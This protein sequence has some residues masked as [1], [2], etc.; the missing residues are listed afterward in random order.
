MIARRGTCALRGAGDLRLRGLGGRIDSAGRRITMLLG[1]DNG[2]RFAEAWSLRLRRLTGA[3]GYREP[4]F[5]F[6]ADE[7]RPGDPGYLESL[8]RIDD[9]FAEWLD[10]GDV[11]APAASEI[12]RQ[13][14]VL[15]FPSLR[16][17]GDPRVDRVALK[18]YPPPSGA[19]ATGILF[20]H[21]VSVGS[22]LAID[23]L[24]APLT[25]RFRVAAMVAP[26]HLMR[27]APGLRH[28]EGFV[29]PNPRA[30]LE[31]LR[32][33]QAD[34]EAC[35]ALL[36][37]DHGFERS[38][39]VGYSLG[40]YGALI[41]RL[42]RPP[43]PTVT[44]CVTNCYAR[45][46]FDGYHTRALRRRILEAG[47]DRD[48]FVRATRSLHIARWAEAIGGDGLTWLYARHD[49]IEPAASLAEARRAVA[50]ERLEQLPGGHSTAL[51]SRRRIVAEVARRI[52]DPS[53][54][55]DRGRWLPKLILR[56]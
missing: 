26:H 51:L 9:S 24:L 7:L 10:P 45:G 37:R 1:T 11:E 49:G 12:R 34:H 28:G 55:H 18:V 16:R 15:R 2:T 32:Q 46:V 33:W 36:A 27:R 42:I 40:A 3:G 35:L 44:I 21:W 25:R 31:G 54:H 6:R 29:N 38:V 22:W 47:F 19:P 52:E 8:D 53:K 56:A 5:Y 43:R 13:D 20:H 4:A 14:G 17:W 23:W 41:N 50:P 39:V 30:I 48:S